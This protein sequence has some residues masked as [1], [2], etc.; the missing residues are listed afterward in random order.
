MKYIYGLNKSGY[1][2]INFLEKINLKYIVLC[3]KLS[4]SGINSAGVPNHEM[5]TLIIDIKFDNNYF[6][7]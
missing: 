6:P 1:S 3:E 2:I 4:V 7:L 5:K